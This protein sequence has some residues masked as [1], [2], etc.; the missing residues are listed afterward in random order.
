MEHARSRAGRG[1]VVGA[2]GQVAK[3]IVE[4]AHARLCQQRRWVFNEKRIVE[5]AGL[6][7]AH[8][9]LTGIPR[10]GAEEL[11]RWVEEAAGFLDQPPP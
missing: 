4:E 1:D 5:R 7:H 6:G 2:A 8:A 9:L 11:R 10:G 3:A